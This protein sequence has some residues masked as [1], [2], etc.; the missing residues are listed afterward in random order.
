[1][2]VEREPG[3]DRNVEADLLVSKQHFEIIFGVKGERI[4]S[5][6]TQPK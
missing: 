2:A 5:E 4:N 1:V 3:P 6:L